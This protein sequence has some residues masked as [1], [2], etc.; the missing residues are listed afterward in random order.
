MLEQAGTNF[1]N[2]MFIYDILNGD[3]LMELAIVDEKEKNV[4]ETSFYQYDGNKINFIGSVRGDENT[5]KITGNGKVLVKENSKLISNLSYDV[6][7]QLTSSAGLVRDELGSLFDVNLK[8]QLKE[9]LSLQSSKIDN[10]KTFVVQKGENVLVLEMDD[11]EWMSIKD[12]K[13]NIGWIKILEPNKING[14]NF[15]DVFLEIKS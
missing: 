6:T 5:I 8:L 12:S 13:D 1:K 2:T 3:K 14:E 9:D 15:D 11:S 7:Y 4:Y 10:S